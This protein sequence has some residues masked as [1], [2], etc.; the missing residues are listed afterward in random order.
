MHERATIPSPHIPTDAAAAVTKH[1]DQVLANL[2]VGDLNVVFQPILDL[3]TGWTV[4]YEA[5]ARC[6]WPEFENPVKLFSQAQDEGQVGRLGRLVRE[7]AFQ[8][9]DDSPL[10]VNIHPRELNE[11]WLVRPDD[12]IFFHD[13]AVYLEVTESAA[14]HYF[15]VCVSVLR[16]VAARGGGHLVVDDL[17]AGY[18]NLKRVLDLEPKIVKLDLALVR[19][20]D[21]NRRQQILVRQVVALCQELGADVVAEGIETVEELRAIRDT[22]AQYGQGYLFAR[23]ACPSPRAHWPLDRAAEPASGRLAREMSSGK[24]RL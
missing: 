8:L 16:E 2:A 24:I 7:V 20:I 9:C 12:P 18:S 5:L 11:G 13:R 6:K 14:F 21:K 15:D 23:P 3:A 4:A 10:F 1:E 17:G 22:G 19:D